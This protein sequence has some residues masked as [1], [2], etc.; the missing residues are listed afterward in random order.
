M[1]ESTGRRQTGERG[2]DQLRP[3][4][5]F[6]VSPW[7][8]RRPAGDGYDRL[9]SFVFGSGAGPPRHDKREPVYE[10]VLE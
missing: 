2:T 5:E 7:P 1:S 8:T 10:A 9:D 6:P 4:A 3:K